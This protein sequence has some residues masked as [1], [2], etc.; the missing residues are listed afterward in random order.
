MKTLN[1][2]IALSGI[3]PNE[4]HQTKQLWKLFAKQPALPQVKVRCDRVLMQWFMLRPNGEY[5]CMEQGVLAQVRYSSS[6]QTGG[7]E[8]SSKYIGEAIGGLLLMGEI[9]QT[10]PQRLFSLMFDRHHGGFKCA[11]GSQ[12]QDLHS[13]DF[14]IL[15]PNCGSAVIGPK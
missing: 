10:L 4:I 8:I 1:Q 11:C 14:L 5:E 3:T 15:K 13:S 7:C 6:F 2:L 12:Q 9:P